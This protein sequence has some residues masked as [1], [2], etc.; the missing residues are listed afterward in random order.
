MGAPRG[1]FGDEIVQED[2]EQ[3]PWEES[4][5]LPVTLPPVSFVD[6]RGIHLVRDGILDF[7]AAGGPSVLA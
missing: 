1:S 6:C 7:V 2:D 3:R 5:S 4:W